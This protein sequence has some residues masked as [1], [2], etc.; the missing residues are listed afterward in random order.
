MHLIHAN[1]IYFKLVYVRATLTL[2]VRV[3]WIQRALFPNGY[4]F[5]GKALTLQVE[6]SEINIELKG[7]GF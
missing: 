4:F 3:G 2:M 1:N 6:A 7:E 5:L